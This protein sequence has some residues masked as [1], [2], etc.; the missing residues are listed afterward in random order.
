MP[1]NPEPVHPPKNKLFKPK[2]AGGENAP[3]HVV[4]IL[5]SSSSMLSSVDTT[6]S[7]YN[8][9]LDT[10][11]KEAIDSGI[12]TIVSLYTFDGRRINNLIDRK[13]ILEVEPISTAEYYPSGMT[14]LYDAIGNVMF[15]LNHEFKKVAKKD[16]ESVIVTILTDGH[17]NASKEF[18]S[19]DIKEM[20]KK[21]ENKG[22][23]FMFL[24]AN[25]DA[26]AV[27]ST[28]GMGQ[29]NTVQYNMTN[30]KDAVATA[31]VATNRI[32]ESTRSGLNVATA[33]AGAISD[34]DRKKLV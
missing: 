4:F 13:N 7:G 3:T 18:T 22:W 23:A 34:E 28:L 10:Q 20:V 15:N 8:E 5:D 30:I 26:F 14:N 6:V 1:A 16:R 21:S 32:K 19:K 29:H 12:D 33:Y 25:I 11:R 27:G 2:R 24:G 31:S 17:E 9:Y